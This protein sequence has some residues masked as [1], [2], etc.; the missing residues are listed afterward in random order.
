MKSSP[1]GHAWPGLHAVAGRYDVIYCDV[2]GVVH[3]GRTGLSAAGDA[4]ARFRDAG[5][6]VVL[7]TNAPRPRGP[8]IRMLDRMGVRRDAYDAVV[9]SGDVTVEQ[10][11]ARGV[12]PA[13]HMGPARDRPL[14]EEAAAQL[15]H[16]PPL[17]ALDAAAYVVCSGMYDD[18]DDPDS[19]M[20][21][22]ET[23]RR[24]DLPLLCANPDIVVHAGDE[25]IWCAG[26]IAERYDALGGPVTLIGKPHPL[27][28]ATA[29]DEARRRRAG[30]A[31]ASRSLA[32]GDGMFT[33][34]LGA[35]REGYDALFI[36]SGIHRDRLGVGGRRAPMNMQAYAELAAEA[37]VSPVGHMADLVW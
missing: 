17:V 9:S 3:D 16:A 15:G 6:T 12:E 23:M 11:V 36:A 5:G 24:R 29:R 31:E 21:T 33:D 28:Y 19:Y 8:I 1:A 18:S 26:A 35:Q 7:I 32:I 37:G 10:I 13:H 22:L 34:M 20:P 27:I 25:L 14:F 4:L 2:W 30:P